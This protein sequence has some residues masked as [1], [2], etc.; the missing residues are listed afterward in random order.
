MPELHF[1]GVPFN[2]D[3]TPPELEHPPQHL[4][5]A[6]LLD[7]LAASRQVRDCG[8]LP[9]PVSDGIRDARTGILNWSS[10][11]TVTESIASAV[12]NARSEGGWPLVVGG[13]CSILV[14]ILAGASKVDGRCGL[15]FLD[16][17]GDFHTPDT[18]PTGEPADM[19]LAV[20]TG[21]A[22]NP[23]DGPSGVVLDDEDVVVLGIRERDGIDDSP[24]RVIDHARLIQGDLE[25]TVREAALVLSEK[26]VWLHFDVDVVDAD[27]MPVIFP[28]GNGLTFEQ[29]ETVLR[30]LLESGR[31]IGM[32]VSCFHPNLDSAGTATTGL[33]DL[34]SKVLGA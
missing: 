13:D 10:W 29:A 15:F 32:D 31:V 16:G 24:I 12:R 3:G 5:N 7:R 4:R 1:I 30:T 19:E 33:V 8:D 26:P 23:T 17:H 2:S 21:R 27:L 22:P 11:Q 28:A 20:L 9:I 14:G 34:L 25:V 6:G 18:S